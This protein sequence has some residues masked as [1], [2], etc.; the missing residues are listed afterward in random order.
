MACPFCGQEVWNGWDERI[1]LDHAIGSETIDRRGEA[2]PLTCANCG[3][4][5][6][7]SD[8]VLDDP[9]EESRNTRRLGLS[10]ELRTVLPHIE[11]AAGRSSGFQNERRIWALTASPKVDEPVGEQLPP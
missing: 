8:H 11:A 5:R 2:F 4:I 9:R 1:A 7:Q 6:F 3:F 10:R